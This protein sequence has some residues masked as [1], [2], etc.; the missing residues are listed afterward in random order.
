ML[1]APEA[2]AEQRLNARELERL[3]LGRRVAHREISPGVLGAFLADLDRHW[4]ALRRVPRRGNAEALGAI[5]TF[6][7]ELTGVT[8]SGPSARRLPDW[9]EDRSCVPGGLPR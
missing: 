4:L 1:V 2:S 9:L 6:A 8:V 7:R 5:E 3:G